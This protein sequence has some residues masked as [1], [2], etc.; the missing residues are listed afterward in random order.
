MPRTFQKKIRSAT[1]QALL[2]A[3]PAFLSSREFGPFVRQ[4]VGRGPSLLIGDQSEISLLRASGSQLDYRMSLLAHPGDYVLVRQRTPAFEEY[5]ADYLNLVDVTFLQADRTDL[6]PVAAQALQL[7]SLI[8]SCA[9]AAREFGGLTLKPYLTSGHIW[10]LAKKISE[11]AIRDVHVCGPSPRIMRR[12]NDKLWFSDLARQIIGTSATPPTRAAYGPAATAGLVRQISRTAKQVIIKVPD[13][14]GSAGNIRLAS[15]DIA[16]ISVTE[17]R[18]FLLSRLRRTGWQDRYPVLVG[19]WD[20]NVLC[21]PSVQ[22]WLPHPQDGRPRVDGIFEQRVKGD[23]G[24]F[25]GAARSTL[26]EPQQ[27]QLATEACQ[28]AAV[29]QELGYYGR[30]SLDAVICADNNGPEIIH[31]IECN[32]RWG[33]VSIPMTAAEQILG[34]PVVPTLLVVQEKLPDRRLTTPGMIKL[35]K[36]LLFQQGHTKSG[37]IIMSPPESENGTFVNLLAVGESQ[38]R[39]DNYIAEAMKRIELVI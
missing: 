12:A 29:L 20:Q 26:P 4:G 3:E 6:A 15:D 9:D 5:L 30:C 7:D 2:T 37:L 24:A 25:V 27:Q 8:N 33:G 11:T 23:E 19:V 17:L 21:S 1:A 10:R 34:E 32:G 31:W 22:L 18:R 38:N 14:A 39:A 35:L 28:I 16:D 36:D 13:S